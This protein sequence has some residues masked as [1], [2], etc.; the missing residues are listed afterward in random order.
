MDDL[1]TLT[2][3]DIATSW[4]GATRVFGRFGLD[5]CC[6]GRRTLA[7]ACRAAGLDPRAIL[8]ELSAGP[9]GADRGDL[10]VWATAPL[11][12]LVT[13]LTDVVHARL[14]DDL[15]ELVRLASAVD[16]A[17]AQHPSYSP[18]VTPLLVDLAADLVD[19]MAVEE[20]LLFPQVLAARAAASGTTV[21]GLEDDHQRAGAALARLR[22]LTHD[23][24]AP[25][26]GC[27]TWRAL[28]SGLARF[29]QELTEHVHLENNVLFPRAMC[30][31]G[32]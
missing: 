21:R 17:H 4:P 14:R 3:G 12:D 18:E 5:F 13:Y 2:L 31:R 28:M 6:G 10:S 7:E 19:H 20:K 32:Q 22:V 1:Q 25:A 16:R 23:Y 29:A 26:D 8:D 27:P 15:P 30:E 9:G 11:A 24:T